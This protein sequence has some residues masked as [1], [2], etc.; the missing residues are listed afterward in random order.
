ER[1]VSATPLV[2]LDPEKAPIVKAAEEARAQRKARA[3]ERAEHITR[4]KDIVEAGGA[5]AWVDKQL[6]EKGLFVD[7]DPS[8]VSDADKGSFKEKKRAEGAEKRRLR[9]L[10]W[11]AQKATHIGHVGAGIFYS[12]TL[13]EETSERDARVAR[14]KNNDLS[15][16]DTPDALAKGLGI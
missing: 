16:L 5:D 3:Q 7:T 14:A 15:S 11:A 9:K 10:A 13:D 12:D 8:T 4:W 1:T 6:R 2:I